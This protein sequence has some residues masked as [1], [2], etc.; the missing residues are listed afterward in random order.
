MHTVERASADAAKRQGS[1]PEPAVSASSGSG[2]RGSRVA[3]CSTDRLAAEDRDRSG[4]AAV[5]GTGTR[6]DADGAGHLLARLEHAERTL[7]S[8]H[9]ELDR[10]QRL[11]TVGTIAGLIAHEFNN[12]LTPMLGYTQMALARPDDPALAR[13]ALERAH[14]SGERAAKIAAAILE[15]LRGDDTLPPMPASSKGGESHDCAGTRVDVALDRAL[16]CLGRELSR[17]GITLRREWGGSGDCGERGEAE[18]DAPS[19]AM[20]GVALEH[21]LL[22]LILNARKAMLSTGQARAARQGRRHELIVRARIV[23]SARVGERGDSGGVVEI[24]VEDN[25][26]GMSA[27]MVERLFSPLSAS[28]ARSTQHAASERD[29]SGT[30]LGMTVCKRLIEQA[31]GEIG[32]RSEV[33]RGTCVWMRVPR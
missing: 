16:A 3:G 31:G 12:I 21:V 14:E 28:R 9:A 11:A 24:E 20:S 4:P 22:N 17:D 19:V 10:Q 18:C 13:R 33:G 23:E 32:V 15:L 29:T 5:G 25:G 6:H 2:V 26:P 27:E 30:G 7:E 1:R 8:L